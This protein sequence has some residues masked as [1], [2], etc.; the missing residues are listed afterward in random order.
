M[1]V[2]YSGGGSRGYSAGFQRGGG[3]GGGGG[4]RR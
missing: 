1:R 3:G 4:R 2:G